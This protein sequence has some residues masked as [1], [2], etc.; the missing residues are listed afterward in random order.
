MKRSALC[1]GVRYGGGEIQEKKTKRQADP[2]G[3]LD[4]KQ[5]EELE[6]RLHGFDCQ[7]YRMQPATNLGKLPFGA[8]I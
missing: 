2:Y 4:R 1:G 5:S 7:A 8:N 6:G 3:E